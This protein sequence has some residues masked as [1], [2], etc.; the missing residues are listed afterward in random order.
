METKVEAQPKIRAV[1]SANALEDIIDEHAPIEEIVMGLFQEGTNLAESVTIE[2]YAT[3]QEFKEAHAAGDSAIVELEG[4]STI[5]DANV[6]ILKGCPMADE[7]KK[8]A[9]DGA[10]PK[11]HTRIINDYMA[12]NPG[13]NA[14]LNPGCIAHQVGRQLITKAITIG[15]EHCLNYYQLACRSSDTGKVVYDENGLASIGMSEAQ[16]D[17]LIDG[18]GCLYVIIRH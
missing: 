16:A 15:G 4:E 10:P 12:Q 18:S 11:F 14:I 8:L 13:S 3:W 6:V 7:M 2:G 5:D 17:K 9:L 1:L